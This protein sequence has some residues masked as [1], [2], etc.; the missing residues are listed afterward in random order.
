M[1]I[2]TK[3]TI[4][5][6]ALLTSFAAGRFSTPEKVKI[7]TKTVEV[8]KKTESTDTNR[9]SRQDST[10]TEI[11]KPDGT[12]EKT[13]HTTVDTNT[14]RA[15][16]DTTT[17]S[18]STDQLKEVTRGSAPTT[19]LALG[20]MNLTGI[21]KPVYGMSVSKP[22]LGPIAVGVWGF[23]NLTVGAGIGLQF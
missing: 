15:T 2:K 5:V 7:E 10:T 11:T 14:D 16:H 17:D 4:C 1:T 18:K 3:I 21:P 23:S 19:I 12:V 8:E 9:S 22:L 6:V 13:T 20:G